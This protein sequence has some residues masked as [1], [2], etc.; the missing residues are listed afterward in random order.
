MASKK[1]PPEGFEPLYGRLEQTVARLEEG[2]LTLEESLALYEEG[3][4]LARR[5]QEL[6][7]QA[8]LKVTRLQEQFSSGLGELREELGEYSPEARAEAEPEPEPAFEQD[9]LPL[10]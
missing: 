6:L 9:E 2:G 8:E 7:Q 10:E 5:C 4:K 3:M 1:A